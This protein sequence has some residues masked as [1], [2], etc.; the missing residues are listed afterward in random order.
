MK[1][2]SLTDRQ[3]ERLVMNL[4]RCGVRVT[5]SRADIWNARTSPNWMIVCDASAGVQ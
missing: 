2:F 1:S 3:S 4:R 5:T